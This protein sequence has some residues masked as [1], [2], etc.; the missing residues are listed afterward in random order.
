ML[1]HLE[2]KYS[3]AEKLLKRYAKND[4]DIR[5]LMEFRSTKDPTNISNVVVE[6][7]TL[8]NDVSKL[9]IEKEILLKEIERMQQSKT[10]ATP[11]KEI[12]VLQ[13]SS[14]KKPIEETRT[15]RNTRINA[16]QVV[17]RSTTPR[18]ESRF[19]MKEVAIKKALEENQGALNT[20]EKDK[21]QVEPKSFSELSSI[22][23]EVNISNNN[24]K[25]DV[26][27]DPNE[28]K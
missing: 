15:L 3:E 4:I 19:G 5:K 11:K 8:K 10:I 27:I 16:T 9:K 18:I 26:D 14:I 23:N 28:I 12:P 6:N 21:N 20:E 1:Q 17:A 7:E 25:I 2:K 22:S 24:A 13:L